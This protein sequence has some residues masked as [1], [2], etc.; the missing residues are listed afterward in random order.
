MPAGWPGLAGVLGALGASGGRTPLPDRPRPAASGR[1]RGS[2]GPLRPTDGSLAHLAAMRAHSER[3][4][5]DRGAWACDAEPFRVAGRSHPVLHGAAPSQEPETQVQP[6]YILVIGWPLYPTPY[7][8]TLTGPARD[9]GE[10]VFATCPPDATTSQHHQ[11]GAPCRVAPAGTDA[12]GT[13]ACAIV[14]EV[15]GDRPAAAEATSQHH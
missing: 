9:V 6:C 4:A 8:E 7:R 14:D 2:Q 3:S 13:A 10:P 5:G 1:P 15:L 11:M 12:H